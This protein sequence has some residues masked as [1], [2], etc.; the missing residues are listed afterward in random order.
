[1]RRQLVSA[2]GFGWMWGGHLGYGCLSDYGSSARMGRS[3]GGELKE[4]INWS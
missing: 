2:G 1:M 3:L 4:D